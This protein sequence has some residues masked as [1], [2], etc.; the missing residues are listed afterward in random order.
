MIY[1]LITQNRG[2]PVMLSFRLLTIPILLVLTIIISLYAQ[3]SP[4][5]VELIRKR[6]ETIQKILETAGET[7]DAATKEKLKNIINDLIDFHELSRLALGKYWKERTEQEKK[8]FVDVF[9]TLI[10]NSSVKKLEIYRADRIEYLP[11]EING[12]KAAVT[13]IAYKGNKSVEIIYKMHRVN[14]QWKVYDMVIDGLSTARNY[15]DTFYKQIAKSS[16]Q[17]MYSKLKKRVEEK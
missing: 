12:D 6:N 15:R 16:Y 1:I 4:S 14:G 7:V 3:S 8:E 17:E 10:R 13:T 9:R 5:P 2:E 11:S